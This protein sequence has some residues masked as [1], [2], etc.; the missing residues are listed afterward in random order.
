MFEKLSKAGLK[1]KLGKCVIFRT[2][3]SYVGHVASKNGLEMTKNKKK[4]AI[5]NW[6]IPFTVTDV[7]SFL[8]SLIIMEYLSLS[9]L[10]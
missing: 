1:L 3:L 8:G 5:T 4:E 10:L 7:S 2:S 6:P 9:M